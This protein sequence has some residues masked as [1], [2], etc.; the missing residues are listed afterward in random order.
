MR[1]IAAAGG[2]NS[3]G[4]MGNARQAEVRVTG[5]T[6]AVLTT[7]VAVVAVWAVVV[8]GD[9]FRTQVSDAP[10]PQASINR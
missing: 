3:V 7:L 8:L 5:L 9:R 10:V 2:V 6:L 1:G 4:H